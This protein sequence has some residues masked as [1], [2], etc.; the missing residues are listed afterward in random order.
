MTQDINP[1]LSPKEHPIPWRVD[2][3]I[4]GTFVNDA[5]GKS[6]CTMCTA[7]VDSGHG[8][9]LITAQ[10]IVDAVNSYTALRE[11]HKIALEYMEDCHNGSMASARSSLNRLRTASEKVAVIHNQRGRFDQRS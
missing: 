3:L 9:R 5:L 6:L 2:H 10:K 8:D 7:T 4:T 1:L 11:F